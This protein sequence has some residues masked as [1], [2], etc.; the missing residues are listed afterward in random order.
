MKKIESQIKEVAKKLLEKGEVK[1]I[2]GFEQGTLPLRVTPVFIRKVED[3]ERLV[4]NSLCTNNLATYLQY[5]RHLF[6]KGEKVGVIAKGCDARSVVCQL[7]EKQVKREEIFIIGISCHG[8][9][10]RRKIEDEVK[11]GEIIEVIEEEKKI[12]LK[13]EDFE[14]E[15]KKEDYLYEH[16]LAC[17][18]KKP[19]L[20][21][22]FIDL[23]YELPEK[24]EYLEIKMFEKKSPKE[25]WEYFCNEVSKCIRCYACRNSCPACYCKECFVDCTS[26][27]WIGT[28]LRAS[29]VQLFH[30]IRAFH[31]AGR[32]VNCGNCSQACPMG[33]DIGFLV[34][35]LGKD[36]KEFFKIEVG[37]DPKAKPA[38]NF[39]NEDDPNQDF[40]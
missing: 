10:D 16:C 30:I 3:I 33:I 37:V 1:L 23:T 39:Y 31:T 12:L 14:K 24:E 8:M 35:K 4:W 11:N 5:Y 34:K 38:L 18:Y 15:L 26:P 27:Q 13:G 2:I 40:R 21:D 28:T 22:E 25:R 32:C 20:Y 17:Q 6:D 19:V 36:V 29:D 9:L 7:Q